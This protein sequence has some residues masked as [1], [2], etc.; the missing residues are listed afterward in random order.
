MYRLALLFSV[1]IALNAT[2]KN[3]KEPNAFDHAALMSEQ[4]QLENK[5]FYIG[6]DRSNAIADIAAIQVTELDEEV[7]LGFDTSNYLPEDFNALKGKHDLD[8]STIEL[9]E[10]EEDVELGFDTADYLPEGFN[11]LKGKHDIDWSSIELFELD[12]EV[13]L[14]FDTTEYLPEDFNSLKGID[15]LAQYKIQVEFIEAE[16]ELGYNFTKKSAVQ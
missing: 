5:I 15:D 11:A 4:Q 7:E 8:W 2:A 12:E 14:C 9:I 10:P 16:E 13:E 3:D 1:L 6:E